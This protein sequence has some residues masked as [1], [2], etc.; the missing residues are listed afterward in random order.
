MGRERAH[1][2]PNQ[3]R[4]V[5]FRGSQKGGV[6]RRGAD[7]VHYYGLLI[8]YA[9]KFEITVNHYC[10]MPN[11]VH[12]KVRTINDKLAKFKHGVQ[13]SYAKY[14]CKKYGK[15]GHIW[16]GHGK[17]PLIEDDVYDATCSIYIEKN[18]IEAGLVTRPENW[19]WSSYRHY[20]LGEPDDLITDDPFYLHMGKTTKKRQM[21]YRKYFALVA[22]LDPDKDVRF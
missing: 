7:F 10:L 5:I 17:T 3:V 2:L 15:V 6:F 20:A 19:Y 9:N 21:A 1:Y 14:F 16:Q 18:P 11:H 12:I 8:K 22:K 13:S 4:H